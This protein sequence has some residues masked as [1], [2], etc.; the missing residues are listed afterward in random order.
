[1]PGERDLDCAGPLIV[2]RRLCDHL[3]RAGGEGGTVEL[4]EDH[5]VTRLG[6]AGHGR[7]RRT[8]RLLCI[9]I[10]RHEG[11]QRRSDY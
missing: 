5:I 10:W 3:P 9:G 4:E 7:G 2:L 8:A 11:Q 6:L 1:M